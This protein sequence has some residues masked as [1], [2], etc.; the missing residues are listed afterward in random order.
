MSTARAAAELGWQPRRSASDAV[1]EFLTGLRD[2]AGM[3]T[4]P[5]AP[6]TSGPLRAQELRTGVGTRP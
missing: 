6:A 4:A 5:L 3:D 1:A 2:G